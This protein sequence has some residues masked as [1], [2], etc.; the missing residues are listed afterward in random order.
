MNPEVKNK[1]TDALRS[2][3]FKQG[4]QVLCFEGVEAYPEYCYLGVLCEIYRRENGGEWER[5]GDAMFRGIHFVEPGGQAGEVMP[6]MPVL[7]W[8]EIPNSMPK[9]LIRSAKRVK[10]NRPLPQDDYPLWVLSVLNDGGA[11]FEQI[12]AVIEE[13]L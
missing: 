11:T 1:W 4:S 8:A 10:I 3:E 2:G 9:P 13:G 6:P 12:A 7:E 5:R